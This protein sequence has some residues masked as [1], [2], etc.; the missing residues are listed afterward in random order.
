MASFNTSRK[1]DAR[2]A[3]AVR[4]S[5]LKTASLKEVTA[6]LGVLW[7]GSVFFSAA[8]HPVVTTTM[9]TVRPMLITPYSPLNA[10]LTDDEQRA[11]DAKTG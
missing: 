6:D 1:S 9:M 10:K 8:R 7:S 2:H 5:L 11:G 3:S 4:Q